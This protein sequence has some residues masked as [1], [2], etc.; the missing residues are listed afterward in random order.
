MHTTYNNVNFFSKTGLNVGGK[1][2]NIGLQLVLQQYCKTSCTFFCLFY[3]SF[4]KT[5]RLPVNGASIASHDA[6]RLAGWGQARCY[7]KAAQITG[8]PNVNF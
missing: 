4:T 8:A 6:L 1:T 7:I 5:A 2:R 3:R